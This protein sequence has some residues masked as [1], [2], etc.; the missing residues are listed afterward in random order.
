MHFV[1][2]VVERVCLFSTK[3][4]N[5]N[6]NNYTV[7]FAYRKVRALLLTKALVIY[8][9]KLLYMV[10][11]RFWNIVKLQGYKTYGN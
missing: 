9:A 8:V 4:G 3:T 7:G 5:Y 1:G 2:V 11:L 6:Y 10:G